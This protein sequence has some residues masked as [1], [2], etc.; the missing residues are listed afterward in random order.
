MESCLEDSEDGQGSFA[1]CCVWLWML[2]VDVGWGL[3]V[4]STLIS[5]IVLLSF[6][7]GHETDP[8]SDFSKVV[9]LVLGI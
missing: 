5:L 9:W 4:S 3:V 6:F 8:R 2:G 1:E 7:T